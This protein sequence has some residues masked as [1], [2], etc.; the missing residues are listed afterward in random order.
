MDFVNCQVV[1]SY[2]LGVYTVLINAMLYCKKKTGLLKAC[3][4]S[5]R[6]FQYV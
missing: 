4:L 1:N 3:L 5:K 6:K 2:I